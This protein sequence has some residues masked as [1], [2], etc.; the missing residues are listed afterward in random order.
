MDLR[1]RSVLILGDSLTHRGSNTAPNAVDVTEGIDRSSSSPGDLLASQLLMRGAKRVRINAR[2]GRSAWDVVKQN[3]GEG[4]MLADEVAKHPDIVF[5]FLGT[6][7]LHLNRQSVLQAFAM[8][9]NAFL[10]GGA[11]TVIAIG[12]PWF[13]AAKERAAAEG[14]Y[15]DLRDVYGPDNVINFAERSHD[16]GRTSDGVHFTPSGAQAAAARLATAVDGL[17]WGSG[18]LATPVLPVA[19]ALGGGGL[20]VGLALWW[21]RRK[22]RQLSA[23]PR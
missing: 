17:S 15:E 10:R 9:R 18:H 14:I 22:R 2:V 19:I 23:G 7:D 8:I 6:N 4:A 16:L 21:R 11:Q 5:V 1:D 13:G 12:P 20:L 3:G